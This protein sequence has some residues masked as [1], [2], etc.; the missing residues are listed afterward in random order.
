M[1]VGVAMDV[2]AIMVECSLVRIVTI[3]VRHDSDLSFGHYST[4]ADQ[5][6]VDFFA[7]YSITQ[8]P[9]LH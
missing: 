3:Q 6:S 1:I 8:L 9:V 5:S 4:R 2:L 7:L